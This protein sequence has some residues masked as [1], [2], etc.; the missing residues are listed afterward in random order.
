MDVK[1][2]RSNLTKISFASPKNVKKQ[3]QNLTARR[4][5]K[6]LRNVTPMKSVVASCATEHL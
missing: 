5:S 1:S 3:K 6:D 2:E 4:Q